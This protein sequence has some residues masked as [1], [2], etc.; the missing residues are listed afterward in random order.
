MHFWKSITVLDNLNR[1]DSA[2]LLMMLLDTNSPEQILWF[3]LIEMM[4]WIVFSLVLV[5]FLPKKYQKYRA[6]IFIFFVVINVGLLIIG[7][8]LTIIM[9]LFGLSWATHRISRPS[10]ETIYFEEQASQFPM[11]YS[12]FHEGILA[13][14]SEYQDDITSDEKIKSLKI[15]YD[16]NAQG[17]IGLIQHF[18]SDSSDETRLYAFALISTFEKS[19]NQRIKELQEQISY[20]HS[21]KRKEQYSFELA[22]VYWQFIFHGVA[23]EQLTGFYT[24]KIEKILNSIQS[25][26]SAFILLG[27]IKIFNKKYDEAEVYFH[28]AIELGVPQKAMSTFLA[29]IKYGQKKYNEIRQYILP[30]EFDIDLRLKPLIKVWR[31]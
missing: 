11:V 31:G 3:V 25:N 24:Q 26:S 6:E 2:Y 14:K 27:K 28:K 9:L 23:T 4:F 8:L 10:Y 19:L 1:I 15:L 7:V 22:Q 16:S 21:N 30:E 5:Q 12:E 20:A 29:E 18:L 13:L 17:N